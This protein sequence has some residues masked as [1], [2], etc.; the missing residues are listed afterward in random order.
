MTLAENKNVSKQALNELISILKKPY[1][2]ACN[3]CK[4]AGK[5][6]VSSVCPKC[7][8]SGQRLLRLL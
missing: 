2:D 1:Q 7:K 8:G 6:T 5:I 4:G 3:V